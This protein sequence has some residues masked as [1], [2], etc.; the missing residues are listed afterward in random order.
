MLSGRSIVTAAM[1]L[2][3]LHVR[4]R[5]QNQ[6]AAV[7]VALPLGDYFYVNALLDCASDEHAPKCD[8]TIR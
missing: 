7:F 3:G 4:V 8:V 6:L 2:C 1:R 5:F